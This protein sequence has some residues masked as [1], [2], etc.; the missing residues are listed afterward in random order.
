[1]TLEDYLRAEYQGGK[2]DFSL[3]IN[4][5]HGPVVTIYI[6]PTGKDGTTTP[7]LLVSGNEV[8]VAPGS[9]LPEWVTP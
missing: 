3:R 7:T 8:N 5:C 9:F 1:M 2:I 6:H 4:V